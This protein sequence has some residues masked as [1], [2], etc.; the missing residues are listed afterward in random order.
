MTPSTISNAVHYCWC[1]WLMVIV[2]SHNKRIKSSAK[3]KTQSKIEIEEK[4]NTAVQAINL[5][6]PN[7]NS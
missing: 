7:A 3:Y 6:I 4:Q 5:N 2:L 1:G